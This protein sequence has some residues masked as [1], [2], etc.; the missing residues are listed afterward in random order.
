MLETK[1][2]RLRDLMET[3]IPKRI[4]W[5]KTE[6][7]WQLWDAPWEYG[8]MSEEEQEADLKKYIASL[9][10]RVELARQKSETD[11]RYSFEIETRKEESYIGWV[12]SYHIDND[13]CFT[14]VDGLCAIG[15]CIPDRSARGKGYAY[16][17]LTAFISYLL[18]YGEQEIYLQT[19]SGN[20]RMVHIAEKIGFEECCR[21]RGIRSV[22]GEIYDGLTFRLDQKRYADFQKFIKTTHS[23]LS[24]RC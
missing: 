10:R 14:D 20:H 7:E 6:T 23:G 19:W 13:Y 21:K 9:H 16:E 4:Y 3:D 8:E 12:A 5:E 15:I 22:R 18:E 1:N 24:K 11:K 2:I 17:A